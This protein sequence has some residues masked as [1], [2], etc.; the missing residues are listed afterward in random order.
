MK[1]IQIQNIHFQFNN[2]K[3][4]KIFSKKKDE[5]NYLL[6]ASW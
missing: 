1:S 3:N 4:I 5:K 6:D 2:I